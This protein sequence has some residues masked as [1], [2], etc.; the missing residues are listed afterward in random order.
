MGNPLGGI[1]S[2]AVTQQLQTTAT[3]AAGAAGAAGK[4]STG[5]EVQAS[6]KPS[7]LSQSTDI[8]EEIGSA[9]AN[10]RTKDEIK[11][12][13]G[14]TETER[15]LEL[16]EKIKIVEEVPET[17]D[18]KRRFPEESKQ[19][20][21]QEDYLKG[22]KEQFKDPYHQYL[23][24]YEIAVEFKADPDALPK[25][26]I[27]KA[28][29]ALE[30]EHPQYI[31]TGRELSKAAGKL[32]DDFHPDK[33]PDEIR[34]QVFGHVKDHKSLAAAFKDL[35][36]N[37][38]AVD[39]DQSNNQVATGFEKSVDRRLRFLSGE[40]NSMTSTTEDTHLRSVINDMTT[41]KR[42][43]GIH[44]SCMETQGEM[45]RPPISIEQFDGQQYMTKVLD[46]LD[47]QFVVG[48]DFTAL[49]DQMG[50][51]EQPVQVRTAFINKTATL[52][53]EIPE[54]IFANEQVK[55]SLVAAIQD[56]QDSLALEEEGSGKADDNYG[57]GGE[58]EVSEDTLNNFINSNPVSN[59]ILDDLGSDF[60]GA[61]DQEAPVPDFMASPG[62]PTLG[63]G[64]EETQAEPAA[65]GETSTA[66]ATTDPA[67]G[68]SPEVTAKGGVNA[69]PEVTATGSFDGLSDQELM[70]KQDE[71]LDKARDLHQRKDTNFVY[72]SASDAL[73]YATDNNV[74]IIDALK[75]VA[76]QRGK[77]FAKD[78]KVG[79]TPAG[80]GKELPLIPPDEK[81]LKEWLKTHPDASVEDLVKTAIEVLKDNR[82]PDI[83][84]DQLNKDLA[85]L[86]SSIA[87]IDSRIKKRPSQ[88]LKESLHP[89]FKEGPFTARLK[90]FFTNPLA[91]MAESKT[92]PL[93]TDIF[94]RLE[95]SHKFSIRAEEKGLSVESTWNESDAQ[96]VAED[97]QVEATLD[98][99]GSQDTDEGMTVEATFE[100][101]GEG[102]SSSGEGG[103]TSGDADVSGNASTESAPARGTAAYIAAKVQGQVKGEAYGDIGDV[104]KDIQSMAGDKAQLKQL[105]GY[106]EQAE[107]SKTEIPL[108]GGNE[109]KVK[110]YIQSLADLPGAPRVNTGRNEPP[111]GGVKS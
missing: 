60:K 48:S 92:R 68:T 53:R 103:D 2:S 47:K 24:L 78:L 42:L 49:M 79:I 51:G 56:E 106:I 52:I 83:D 76:S 59:S 9:R 67:K 1:Q 109:V 61:Q 17:Q 98:E 93:G 75:Q 104:L 81:A 34:T 85:S 87:D 38:G 101:S 58:T 54:E 30:K 71:F 45:S 16:I 15:Q 62:V 77:A 8:A 7:L 82:G 44:D 99:A 35:N 65:K 105:L 13:K 110:Q 108:L 94:D 63:Q 6:N 32:A 31:E 37:Q 12:T 96:D 36:N 66:K 29:E 111:V 102:G 88:S 33:T 3:S 11:T 25:D 50:L 73:K 43:V 26:E 69:S 70:E 46:L 19:D 28:I 20:Y 27:F 5:Q 40:L 64:S 4:L 97:M 39:T 14:K 22:A 74:D 91:P 72:D 41:L 10:F 95:Y 18:F 100:A 21:K 80:E 23:A 89:R 55:D 57:K 107:A 86:K 90:A 84:L